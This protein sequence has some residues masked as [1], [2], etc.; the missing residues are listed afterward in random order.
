MYGVQPAVKI[1]FIGYGKVCAGLVQRKKERNQEKAALFASE[2]RKVKDFHS[3][4]IRSEFTFQLDPIL[5]IQIEI[6]IH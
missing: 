3:N 6:I 2:R 1:V 4:S 5:R